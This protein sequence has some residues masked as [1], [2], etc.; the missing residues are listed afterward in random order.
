MNCQ[1]SSDDDLGWG[2]IEEW[3]RADLCVE[4]A[5]PGGGAVRGFAG[6]GDGAVVARAA[7]SGAVPPAVGLGTGSAGQGARA[8]LAGVAVAGQRHD[9]EPGFP[10]AAAHV[11]VDATG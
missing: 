4:L 11:A 8:G 1:V 9:G 5:G 3:V 6:R 2:Y 10:H 7:G